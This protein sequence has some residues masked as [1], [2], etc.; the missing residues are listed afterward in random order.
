M[1]SRKSTISRAFGEV[2]NPWILSIPVEPLKDRDYFFPTQAEA[3]A[4]AKF[5]SNLD[6]PWKPANVTAAA[7]PIPAGGPKA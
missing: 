4:G 7:E 3:L 2:P 5:I 6:V 1:K